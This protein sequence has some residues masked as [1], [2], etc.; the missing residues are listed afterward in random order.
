MT[1]SSCGGFYTAGHRRGRLAARRH[2]HARGRPRSLGALTHLPRRRGYRPGRRATAAYAAC[3]PTRAISRRR[4]WSSP[5]ASGARASRGW[6]APR[7][8]DAGRAPDDQ[9]RAGAALRRHGRR[10]QVPDR[11]RHG[12]QH[13][14]APARRRP[15]SRLVRAPGHPVDPDDIPSIAASKPCR[16]PRLPF[17]KEDFDPQ[18][19]QA[20]ELVPE[21]LGDERVG[22]RYAING[23]LSLT[24]DGNPI[25]GE[26][27]EV[28]GLWSVAAV[29][30]KEAPGYRQDRRRVDDDRRAGDR[31]ARLRHRAL[32]RP[33]AHR[34][35]HP[36]P[37]G[38]GL[39]TRPTASSTRASSGQSN[40]ER[41]AVA[42]STPASAR[43]APCSSRPPAGSG[44]TGT[45][46]T[47]RCWTKYGDG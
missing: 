38:R 10:D 20:L 2:A 45:R 21:I 22:I 40:R 7:P 9:R 8:A 19:E 29:W 16:R 23:L 17:T 26:T 43:S 42:R 18:M 15:G 11:A 27:P 44:P 39:S 41:P 46:P 12:H 33:S 31:S 13:V 6:P 14:R 4:S 3:A 37:D 34:A 35:A 28:K 24:P 36:G 1:R 30:I 5:A 32:L 25:L 47:G